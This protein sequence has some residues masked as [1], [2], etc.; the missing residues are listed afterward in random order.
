[1]VRGKHAP[2]TR[3]SAVSRLSDVDPAPMKQAL[4]GG[5]TQ[6]GQHG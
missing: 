3:G 1:M 5:F 2:Y 6:Y 4:S